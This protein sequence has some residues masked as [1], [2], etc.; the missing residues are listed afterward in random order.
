MNRVIVVGCGSHSASDEAAGL[1]VAD[2]L[3]RT[4]GHV[5]EVRDMTSCSRA[6]VAELPVDTVVIFVDA[7]RSGAR[8]GTFHGIALTPSS[9]RIAP[10]LQSGS[11]HTRGM[12]QEIENLLHIPEP[13]PRM[14]W[15]GI[16]IEKWDPGFGITTSVH[17]AVFGSS[18]G[19][20]Q[21]QWKRAAEAALFPR[22]VALRLEDLNVFCL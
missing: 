16:E 4:P 14:Y 6:F 11:G 3:R 5:C 13:R 8:P 12:R 18:E 21:A 10:T 9:E 20:R 1:D 19:T 2:Q 17:S 15:I 22:N 7:V